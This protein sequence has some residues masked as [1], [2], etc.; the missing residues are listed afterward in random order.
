MTNQTEF[1]FGNPT[2]VWAAI[3]AFLLILVALIGLLLWPHVRHFLHADG[4]RHRMLSRAESRVGMSGLVTVALDPISYLGRVTVDDED[5]A[6]KG[7][8]NAP[9]GSK[10][11][12]TG[13]DGIHLLVRSTRPVDEEI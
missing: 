10:V 13:S 3:A 5:W 4:D 11:Q 8:S 7:T 12:I 2:F 1:L 6:A 9:V